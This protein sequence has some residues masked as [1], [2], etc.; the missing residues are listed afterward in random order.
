M[1]ILLAVPRHVVSH[2]YQADTIAGITHAIIPRVRKQ[3]P[4]PVSIALFMLAGPLVAK[5]K[6]KRA[7]DIASSTCAESHYVL[8]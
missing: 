8:P 3:R 1:V 4:R 7:R 6:Q 5:T 2:P